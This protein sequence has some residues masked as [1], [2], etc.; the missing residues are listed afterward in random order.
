V[1][2]FVGLLFLDYQT[3]TFVWLIIAV[4]LLGTIAILH[5]RY[6]YFAPVISTDNLSFRFI[7]TDIWAPR[8][9]AFMMASVPMSW[10]VHRGRL[11]RIRE[12][13]IYK[14][15]LTLTSLDNEVEVCDALL[16]GV[17]S[18]D[19]DRGRVWLADPH[20][21]EFRALALQG[22]HSEATRLL[23]GELCLHGDDTSRRVLTHRRCFRFRYHKP[24]NRITGRGYTQFETIIVDPAEDEMRE[25]LDKE[26]FDEWVE[27]PFFSGPTPLGKLSI[28]NKQSK[29]PILD[30]DIILLS[31]LTAA[32]AEAIQRARLVAA[33]G[34]ANAGKARL[35]EAQNAIQH[36]S[37]SFDRHQTLDAVAQRA[38]EMLDAHIVVVC[39]YF[40]HEAMFAD[41]LITKGTIAGIGSLKAA[42]KRDGIFH[43]LVR[44]QTPLFVTDI[45]DI[46]RTSEALTVEMRRMFERAEL[47]AAAIR[48]L[49]AGEHA[50]PVGM[51]VIGYSHSHVFSA[52][53]ELVISGLV[54]SGSVGIRSARLFDRVKQD[55]ERHERQ[56]EA[57]RTLD[58][59]IVA[60]EGVTQLQAVLD[61]ILEKALA[62]VNAPCGRFWWHDGV[63]GLLEVKTTRGAVP[64]GT[65]IS[66]YEGIIGSAARSGRAFLATDVASSG[67]PFQLFDGMHIQAAVPL[68]DKN[69]VI[70]IIDVQ[71][72]LSDG[73]GEKELALL[74]GF[75]LQA[76]LAV[77][78]VEWYQSFQARIGALRALSV[79][80]ARIAD[81]RHDLETSL[82]LLLTGV[83]AA[84]GLAFSRAM[85]FVTD[86]DGVRLVGKMAIG[87]K[88]R[89][90]AESIWSRL[91]EDAATT[92]GEREALTMLLNRAVAIEAAIKSG[93][94]RDCPLSVA[95]QQAALD[96]HEEGALSTC[97]AS[98][99]P[100]IVMGDEDDESRELL[101]IVTGSRSDGFPFA[102]VPLINRGDAI[103]VLVVDNRFLFRE[104]EIGA[105]AVESLEAFA[106]VMAMSIESARL[107]A[108]LAEEQRLRTWREFAAQVSHI[109]GTRVAVID[110]AV[111][112]L[113]ST[114]QNPESAM[115]EGEKYMKRLRAAVMKAQKVLIEFREFAAPL[116]LR[117]APVDMRHVIAGAVTE[118]AYATGTVVRHAL[119]DH[120]VMISGDALKLG[121]AIIE[122]LTNARQAA[123]GLESAPIVDVSLMEERDEMNALVARVMIRDSGPGV[124]EEARKRIFEPFYT[125][126]G[127]GSG[128]GL[129]I[130]K[131]I[132]AAHNGV[133]EETSSVGGRRANVCVV[134]S[135]RFDCH[136]YWMSCRREEEVCV[137]RI[138]VVEDEDDLRGQLVPVQACF[139]IDR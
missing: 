93:A 31:V 25:V 43:H 92:S 5:W 83:T 11:Q 14:L 80:S 134:R 84:E 26:D 126:K 9:F 116:D 73:F 39:E 53:E 48:P 127:R 106:G 113:D 34:T 76:V 41:S 86:E 10:L 97:L 28:D 49:Q 45:R 62:L 117:M 99:Q 133:I 105:S 32:A 130:V 104:R 123:E 51:I 96:I 129:A 91:R 114:L 94:R 27:I 33:L 68:S 65:K 122:I 64:S 17:R 20:G 103:G 90:E 128:L 74:E 21:T 78:T 59:A 60:G 22:W 19:I 66:A 58:Q 16:M 136:C 111:A 108:R 15:S 56:M 131:E 52:E 50:E 98:R 119:P 118:L 110:G 42:F 89:T 112:Q 87:A 107:R 88:E 38:F 7:I 69:G 137:N 37:A 47:V 85:L 67:V 23:S 46:D 40:S 63:T 54:Q 125:T 55:L 139:E 44:R 120:P 135:L 30:A 81:E 95:V 102:C 8:A 72:A 18:L 24:L 2:I 71:H 109:I 12:N 100:V 3:I 29:R 4:I 121:E 70:G 36:L 75:A 6:V 61:L 115:V 82:R 77:H 79:I 124:P 132:I 138:L 35:I 13:R 101:D 1:P 57:R